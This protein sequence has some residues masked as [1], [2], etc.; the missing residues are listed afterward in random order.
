LGVL[1]AEPRNL[2]EEPPE[3]EQTSS[4]FNPL[5]AVV[6]G[7]ILSQVKTGKVKVGAVN[8]QERAA[9]MLKA[10]GQIAC[11]HRIRFLGR[12]PFVYELVCLPVQHFAGFALRAEIPN[13]LKELAQGSGLLVARAKAK[14][15]AMPCPPTATAALA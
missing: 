12:R 14:V 6:G 3:G 10:G 7:P 4:R 8:D 9:L 13:E 11:F 5:R 15:R 2:C 1:K